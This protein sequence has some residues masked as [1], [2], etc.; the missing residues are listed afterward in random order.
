MNTAFVPVPRCNWDPAT[1][2]R[3][4]LHAGARY[5]AWSSAPPQPRVKLPPAV[6]RR[7]RTGWARCSMRWRAG[8]R[9]P[10]GPAWRGSTTCWR[11]VGGRGGRQWGKAGICGPRA[12]AWPNSRGPCRHVQAAPLQAGSRQGRESGPLHYLLGQLSGA[13]HPTPAHTPTHPTQTHTHTHPSPQR[14]GLPLNSLKKRMHGGRRGAVG[15][16]APAAGGPELCG[17]VVWCGD[18]RAACLALPPWR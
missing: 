8:R 17:W 11:W 4:C 16:A 9:H 7:W 2:C 10:L 1:G 18:L 5:A 13:P 6:H 14:H 3:Q 12:H 15:A